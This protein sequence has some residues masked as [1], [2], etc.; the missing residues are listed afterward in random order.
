MLSGAISLADLLIKQQKETYLISKVFGV[1]CSA[2][3]YVPDQTI[4]YINSEGN[5]STLMGQMMASKQLFLTQYD[6]RLL[7]L[8]FMSVFRLKVQQGQIDND[9][10]RWFETAILTLHVQRVE[11]DLKGSKT[12][13]H[14]SKDKRKKLF[15]ETRSEE[16]KQDIKLYNM[17]IGRGIDLDKL[18][19]DDEPSSIKNEEDDIFH[20][21]LNYVDN[22]RL[23]ANRSVHKLHSPINQVDEFSEFQKIF[24]DFRLLLGDRIGPQVLDRISSIARECLNGVLKSS[25]LKPHPPNESIVEGL[26]G[27]AQVTQAPRKIAKLKERQQLPGQEQP[28]GSNPMEPNLLYAP[29]LN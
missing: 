2:L 26:P 14:I 1:I 24:A 8:A 12:A 7:S 29:Q 11:E 15:K 19:Q 5:F 20:D 10:L 28:P 23:S 16:D 13:A 6:R 27:M 18:L 25:K 9:A 21:I 3:I 22:A 17:I 4:K